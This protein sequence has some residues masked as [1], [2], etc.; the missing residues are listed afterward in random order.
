[1]TASPTF[2]RD[3]G[4]SDED[5]V[6]CVRRCLEGATD[7]FEDIVGRYQKPV[8]NLIYHVVHHY[9]DAREI[10]QTVFLKAFANLKSFQQER[11]FYS[12]L[13]R[14][15]MNESLNAVAARKD[16]EPLVADVP[17]R[18]TGPAE[19]AEAMEIRA[20]LRRALA[21]LTPEQRTVVALR[22]FANLSYREAADILGIEE[23]TVKSRLFSARQIL[24]EKLTAIGLGKG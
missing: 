9:E 7:A 4:T 15:A 11:R 6:R 17:S 19:H 8:F 18:A 21:Q 12:W 2:R 1:M 14:I 16:A 5:D 23:K 13:C 22:H 24:R 3:A 10:A 20:H